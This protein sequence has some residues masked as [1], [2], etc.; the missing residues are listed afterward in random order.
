MEYNRGEE[1]PEARP[2]SS[3]YIDYI[4][5]INS[6]FYDQ[7]RIADQ[8]AAYIFTFLLAFIISSAEGRSVFTWARYTKG[9]ALNNLVAGILALS[10]IAALVSA[11]LV[12][13]PR[14]RGSTTTSLYFKS[15]QSHRAS[16]VEAM[17]QDDPAYIARE[18]LGNIDNLS[19][20]AGS[21]YRFV[22]TAFRS[23]LV[24][25]VAYVLLLLL[26]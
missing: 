19:A 13:I 26:G 7:I 4:K 5:N 17:E 6:T 2:A 11:I 10:L 25:V 18:Y 3:I 16:L 20:I 14:A 24:A 15:W 22:S 12:V 8:K 23:L 1:A 9:A 21:K